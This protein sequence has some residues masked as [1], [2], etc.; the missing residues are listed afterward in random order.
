MALCRLAPYQLFTVVVTF[1]YPV[2]GDAHRNDEDVRDG[3][4]GQSIHY[5]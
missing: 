1:D 5:H 2:V 3:V 4:G